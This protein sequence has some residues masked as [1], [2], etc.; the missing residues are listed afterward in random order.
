MNNLQIFNFESRNIRIIDREG[1]PWFVAKDVCDVLELS[2]V[3]MSIQRLNENQ[4]G[5]SII[6][7]P[8]G[9]QE[10]SIISEPGLYKLV[11][12]S[13]KPEAEKFTDWITSE[14]IPQIRKTGQYIK[15]TDTDPLIAALTVIKDIR[16]K[17]IEMEKKISQQDLEIKAISDKTSCLDAAQVRELNNLCKQ[18]AWK[19]AE[20]EKRTFKSALTRVQNDVKAFAGAL[21]FEQIRLSQAQRV[22]TY[23]N[24]MKILM[25]ED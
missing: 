20:K 6:G 1:N 11:F 16:V 10:M 24:D 8:G 14:V 7:T 18:I 25:Y 19:K 5:T 3:S 4:K 15:P 2:D 23:A 13:R 12:Q 17:Q 9:K 22:F 21:S